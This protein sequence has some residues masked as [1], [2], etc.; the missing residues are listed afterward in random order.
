MTKLDNEKKYEFYKRRKYIRY[1]IIV[2][3]LMVVALAICSLIYDISC[4][5][6]LI[7]F[8]IAT[9]LSKYRDSIDFRDNDNKTNKKKKNK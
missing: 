4:L 3:Y 9:L 2:M 8:I 1:I 5:Y 6:P 7:L